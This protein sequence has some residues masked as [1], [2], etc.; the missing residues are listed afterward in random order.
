M[1]R[2]RILVI[3]DDPAFRNQVASLLRKSFIVAVAAEG[4]DGLRK[5]LEHVPDVITLDVKMEGWDGLRTLKAI[6]EEPALRETP[7]VMLTGDASKETVLEAI[8]S[9]AD[10]LVI[11]A[12]FEREDFLRRLV[13][14]LPPHLAH[15]VS[16]EEQLQVPP[17]PHCRQAV[18]RARQPGQRTEAAT[19]CG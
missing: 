4:C 15:G 6:R 19:R 5:A 12:T 11:K 7:I 10:E 16:V 18:R 14:L 2:P 3:D 9:G 17:A 13:R 1:T 8:A